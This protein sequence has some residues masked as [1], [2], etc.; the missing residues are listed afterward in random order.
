MKGRNYRIIAGMPLVRREYVPGLPG[1]RI[2]KFTSGVTSDAYD[3]KVELK[4]KERAQI[5][6]NALEAARI[7][8]NKILEKLGEKNYFF[9]LKV[10]PHVI[11]RENKMITTA[12]ADRLQE[13]M[14]KAWGKPIGLA[15][16]VEEGTVILEAYTTTKFLDKVKEAFKIAASKLPIPTK[17]EIIPLKQNKEA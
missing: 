10:Y 6:Q 11:L 4:A 13:G 16:R 2:A 1:L 15:A 12:G 8:A 9:V 5:R 7:A 17:I 3:V 14:R